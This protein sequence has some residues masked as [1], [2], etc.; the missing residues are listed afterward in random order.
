M[1][2]H[3]LDTR[4]LPSL[5]FIILSFFIPEVKL[6]CVVCSCDAVVRGKPAP[7]IES[8]N[9]DTRSLHNSEFLLLKLTCALL[10]AAAMLLCAANLLRVLKARIWILE[11]YIILSFI[12]KVNLGFVVCSGDAV[13]RGKPAGARQ[14]RALRPPDQ[15]ERLPG[16]RRRKGDRLTSCIP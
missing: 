5:G 4:K 11:V 10:C 13:V 6:R 16:T 2:S 14:P 15:G 1:K 9:L 12:A 7:S 3:N 8:Q